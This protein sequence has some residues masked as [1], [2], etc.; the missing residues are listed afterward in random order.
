MW[1]P[2]KSQTDRHG[3]PSESHLVTGFCKNRDCTSKN[4]SLVRFNKIN[5]KKIEYFENMA[6][7][8]SRR[9]HCMF[10]RKVGIFS[11]S[12]ALFKLK[13][14]GKTYELKANQKDDVMTGKL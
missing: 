8:K 13:F 3:C 2:S 7:S 6:K 12:N 1:T 11:E 9:G 5:Y 10:T 4:H 14:H